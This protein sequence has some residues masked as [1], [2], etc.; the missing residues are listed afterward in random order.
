MADFVKEEMPQSHQGALLLGSAEI[1][2]SFMEKGNQIYAAN[3]PVRSKN[4]FI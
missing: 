1:L 3:F 2:L 4:P